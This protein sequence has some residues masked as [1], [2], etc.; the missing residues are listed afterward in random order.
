MHRCG[1]GGDPGEAGGS[2]LSPTLTCPHR[3]RLR[4]GLGGGRGGSP[5]PIPP[6]SAPAAPPKAEAAGG[7]VRP[8]S[9]GV[10]A[11]EPSAP[12]R[13]HRRRHRV[14]KEGALRPSRGSRQPRARPA[15]LDGAD[16]GGSRSSRGR[17]GQC[18]ARSGGNS[19]VRGRSQGPGSTPRLLPP[20]P[21]NHLHLHT[22]SHP[23]MPA[24]APRTQTLA[25]RGGWRG[26]G[27][28][29]APAPSLAG[30]PCFVLFFCFD[31]GLGFGPLHL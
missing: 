22:C 24:P 26:G 1:G 19:G 23:K 30:F 3:Q 5:S 9:R 12:G 18:P 7:V 20:P 25:E 31:F 11:A 27:H 13:E 29:G 17:P 2:G 4:G 21:A 6:G 14:E 16:G 8:A 15:P 28:L 10:R